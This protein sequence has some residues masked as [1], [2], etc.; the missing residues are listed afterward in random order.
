REHRSPVVNQLQLRN[1]C[2]GEKQLRQSDHTGPIWS[3]EGQGRMNRAMKTRPIRHGVTALLVT[4]LLVC[5]QQSGAAQKQKG[6]NEKGAGAATIDP[7]QARKAVERGE[8]R[9]AEGRF[10]EALSAYDEAAR[11]A[12]NDANIV[13]RGA[14]LR[15]RIVRGHVETAER[16]GLGRRIR[17]AVEELNKA[18]AIDK[19]NTIVQQRLLE[20]KAMDDD[21]APTMP[22]EAAAGLPQLKPERVRKNIALRGDTRIVYQQLTASYGLKVTF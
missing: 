1:K 12:P 17:Q 5:P 22:P 20:M 7:K 15:S 6:K 10:E 9:E 16:L 21:A 3:S 4:A 8:K 14:A 18:L 11:L 19:G 2:T 13:G